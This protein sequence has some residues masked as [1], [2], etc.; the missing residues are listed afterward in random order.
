MIS[1]QLNTMNNFVAK[2]EKILGV[3]KQIA[4]KDNFL[5]QKRKPKLSDVEVIALSLAA[6]C[7]GFDSECHL[8]RNLP[9]G[10]EGKIE[11]SVYNR[12]RRALFPHYEMIRKEMSAIL[13]QG[14]KH[15][16]IDSM[17]LEICKNSRAAR[18]KIC[19]D[20][21]KSCPNM[22]YCAS[23]KAHYYGYKLHAVCGINGVFTSFDVTSASIHDVRYL[24]DVKYDYFNCTLIGDKG[25]IS[26][27]YQLDLF[28][29]SNILLEVPYR[30]NQLDY[31][32]S[33]PIFRIKRKRIETLFSQ[34]CDQFM[35][36][37]NYAK[38]FVGFRV[39]LISKILSLT[40]LQ[41]INF[42]LGRN[43]NSLKS[44]VF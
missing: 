19:K 11:R 24:N 6:E 29:Q 40:C 30:S 12:R 27:Q 34:L 5:H 23:Q 32:D 35:I 2:Y 16:L 38:R 14:C 28:T 13:V 10:I 8:F 33:K 41:F 36:R 9:S 17:P 43:I 37:R 15:F 31:Q 22:G 26:K 7:S 18:S 25:Y 44:L 42:Q 4:Q 20:N 3:V 39:R 1:K 21:E